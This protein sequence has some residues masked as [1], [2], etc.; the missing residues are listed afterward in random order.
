MVTRTSELK[1]LQKLYESAGNQLVLLSGTARSEKERLITDFC[2]DKKHFYFRARNISGPEQLQQFK[3]QVQHTY[4]IK[5]QKDS[6]DECFTRMKSGN[7]SKLVVVIDE[8][9]TM[10]KNDGAFFESVLR[11]K[12]RQLYPGPVMILLANSSLSFTRRTLADML[13]DGYDA[14]DSVVELKD[15]SF[16]DIVRACPGYSLYDAV[17]VYGIVGGISA[18]LSRWD[19]TKS[20]KDNV[21]HLILNPYGALFTE[22]EDFIGTELREL[23][24]YDTILY[25]MASGNEKLNDLY[26]ATGY[27]RAKISVYLKNLAAFDVIEKVVSFET[28]GWENA[29]KGIYRIKNPF[30]RF[31][32]HFIYPHQ[33]ELWTLGTDDF[34]ENYIEGEL[35]SYLTPYFSKVCT[36]Y[37]EL[38]NRVGKTPIPITKMGTW[39]G[40]EGT[41]DIVGMSEEGECVTGICNWEKMRMMYDDYQDLLYAMKQARIHAKVTYLFS[42]TEFDVRLKELAKREPTLELVDMKEL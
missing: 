37:L 5:L 21:C 18:Y 2:K 8:F 36:E 13:G 40:K 29:K 28:G 14:I 25:A 10:L 3:A 39:I 17:C 41:I 35:R 38:L 24:V 26:K 9:Q 42:A 33:S 34:Y 31:W 32:F 16:L 6:Y 23:S 30:I 11:L 27:S 1:Q 7:A 22:A 19:S 4:D 20:V 12:N 15:F